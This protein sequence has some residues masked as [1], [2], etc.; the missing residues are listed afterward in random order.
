MLS[1]TLEHEIEGEHFLFLIIPKKYLV[2][3]KS[4]HIHIRQSIQFL[5]Q[6]VFIEHFSLLLILLFLS[7]YKVFGSIF[8]LEILI[9]TY[10]I[11]NIISFI[12]GYYSSVT[13]NLFALTVIL[14]C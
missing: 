13:L 14:K 11:I 8:L 1:L 4:L 12:Q 3:A 6:A 9:N 2:A 5:Q 10:N 7:P